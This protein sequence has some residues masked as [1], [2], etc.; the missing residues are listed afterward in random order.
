MWMRRFRKA[1]TIAPFARPPVIERF[2]ENLP[3]SQ[4]NVGLCRRG[5]PGG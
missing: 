4:L 3:L 5:Q 2:P 1:A